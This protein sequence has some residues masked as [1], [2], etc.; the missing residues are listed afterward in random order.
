M[1]HYFP[2]NYVWSLSTLI[3]LGYGGNIGEI[4]EIC[5]PILD[6]S[7]NGDD[8]NTK[9]F[10]EVWKKFADQ[11]VELANEDLALGRE[12][13]AGE[14]L[15]RAG[16]Y[17]LT[18]ERMQE[19]GDPERVFVY[20]KALECYDLSR[21][22]K[23]ENVT[24][25]EIPYGDSHISA[26]Y[27]KADTG[28]AKS[29]VVVMMNGLDSSKELLY[30]TPLTEKLR[31]RGVSLLC[32]DQP[33]TGEALRLQNLTAVY[34]TEVWASPI[35]DWLY[36]QPEIDSKNIGALGISLGGY[37]APRAVA[38]EPR[39]ACGA[40][41]GANHD[42]REV[43]QARYKNE[44]E[45]PVPHYWKHVEW[46]FGAKDLED[47]FKKAEN[48]HLNGVL[49]NIKVPFLVTHG[50]NDRQ[51]PLKYAY[52]TYEQLVNSPKRDLVVFT[53]REGG[54]E[55][56]SLDNPYNAADTLA[57]WLAEQLN[58]RVA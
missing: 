44:G 50:D 23:K 39:F 30:G 2:T 1:F 11:L 58:C 7:K 51:I 38:F 26:I 48:M 15:E 22:Y 18:A 8:V 4:D 56:C 37:Y 54:V 24:R 5:K 55:H 14:K 20:A 35:V 10:M 41:W 46:V 49:Q 13:S 36:Q 52:E 16:L 28:N 47:F 45:R 19:H 9:A 17:Y 32:I 40:V 43:Q 42:W 3:A 57:D 6:A 25:V 27:I 34:N 31:K 53:A 33:G 29:P 21:K 12:F